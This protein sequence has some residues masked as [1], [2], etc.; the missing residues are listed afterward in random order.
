MKGTPPSSTPVEC[1]ISIFTNNKGLM[2]K[3]ITRNGDSILKTPAA[4]LYEGL[5]EVITVSGLRG[6]STTIKALK[7]NQAITYGVPNIQSSVPIPVTT[8]AKV[9]D[10]AIARS[11]ECMMWSDGVGILMLDYDPRT[12][13]LPLSPDDLVEAV[14]AAVPEL[15]RVEMLW[16]PSA[17]SCIRSDDGVVDTGIGGQRLYI[18]V[19]NASDIPELGANI[20]DRTVLAGHAYILIDKAGRMH[21]RSLIDASV[22]Q[23]ERLDFAAGAVCGEGLTRDAEIEHQLYG[24][25]S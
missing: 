8:K 11:G 10:G 17:S 24:G 18:L 22:W 21:E 12:G 20:F 4:D 9:A 15:K 6:L 25:A 5:C 19:D 13:T 1:K 3:Y 23:P 16:T 7:P 2:T 14:R